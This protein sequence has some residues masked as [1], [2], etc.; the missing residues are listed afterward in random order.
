MMISF[1]LRPCPSSAVS[2]TTVQLVKTSGKLGV[3]SFQQLHIAKHGK[4]KVFESGDVSELLRDTYPERKTVLSD[5]LCFP[6]AHIA[7]S[8]LQRAHGVVPSH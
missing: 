3:L 7:S 5:C 6:Y 4:R 1:K 8:D 2:Y